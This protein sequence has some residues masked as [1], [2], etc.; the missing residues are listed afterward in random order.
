MTPKRVLFGMR[1][2]R[3]LPYVED[4]IRRLLK[5][6]YEISFAL[7][8][9]YLWNNSKLET[10]AKLRQLFGVKF[11]V[12]LI[13]QPSPYFVSK[14]GLLDCLVYLNDRE[15]ESE[16][17]KRH[18]KRI[19]LNFRQFI[20]IKILDFIPSNLRQLVCKK[21]IKLYRANT[22]SQD[23]ANINKLKSKPDLVYLTPSNMYNSYEDQLIAEAK[24]SNIP[25][26]VQALSWDNLNNK[27]S[28]SSIPDRYLV[29][30]MMHQ[31]LLI[32][33]HSI[34]TNVVKIVGSSYT[35]KYFIKT[36]KYSNLHVR[37]ALGIPLDKKLLIFLGSSKNIVKRENLELKSLLDR[38]QLFQNEYFLMIRPHPSNYKIWNN[39]NH[40][41]TLVWPR[42]QSLAERN[43]EQTMSIYS[44]AV[45]AFG[46][47]TS[48]FFDALAC[49]I[50]I[51]GIEVKNASYQKNSRHFSDLY[52]NG[53]LVSQSLD[54][55]IEILNVGYLN[56]YVKELVD[57]VLPYHGNS[58]QES[59][60]VIEQLIQGRIETEI[61]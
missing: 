35:D 49:G 14:K 44:T 5:E 36:P 3:H 17:L 7:D 21:L 50:P 6:N 28:V 45:A 32:K 10:E 4:L 19:N 33:R 31:E 41:N 42:F 23:S 48:G 43:F 46:I 55:I 53:L 56:E 8:P 34:P 61:M 29:W 60:R 18:M 22:Y 24:I 40:E 15:I 20:L 54:D 25:V 39:W 47:N 27:G 58:V 12:V 38:S 51:F 59:I 26:I 57:S 30:N 11:E 52:E 16:Y 1:D 9:N 2:I 37:R 13:D